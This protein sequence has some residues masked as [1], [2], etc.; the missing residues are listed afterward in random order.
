[1]INGS[2]HDRH[3]KIFTRAISKNN[4][5]ELFTVR[6]I[7]VAYSKHKSGNKSS[8][9]KG[10]SPCIHSCLMPWFTE[11][12]S[13]SLW[14]THLLSQSLRHQSQCNTKDDLISLTYAVE[15]LRLT[16][17]L[18]T[19]CSFL[20]SIYGVHA[21]VFCV[22]WPILSVIF[23]QLCYRNNDKLHLEC[24]SPLDCRNT[25]ILPFFQD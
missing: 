3:A 20:L 19:E 10:G 14:E 18:N 2:G 17:N 6:C 21:I 12:K 15:K 1:M 23:L 9:Q 5:T 8:I 13:L 7:N 25:C 22:L 11:A 16:D 24:C 4:S